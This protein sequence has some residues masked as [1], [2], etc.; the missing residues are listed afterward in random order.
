MTR[1][2]QGSAAA[3]GELEAEEFISLGSPARAAPEPKAQ[4]AA[5]SEEASVPGRFTLP[6][7]QASRRIQSPLLR[8]HNGEAVAGLAR[9]FPNFIN[10]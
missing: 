4:P 9:I 5:T 8:L 3:A 1:A 2:W 10:A 6:W 7:A